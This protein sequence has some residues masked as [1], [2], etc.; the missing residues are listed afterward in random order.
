MKLHDIMK[1]FDIVNF[2]PDSLYRVSI[3]FGKSSQSLV[4]RSL[5]TILRMNENDF[6]LES[7]FNGW[8]TWREKLLW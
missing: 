8:I 3:V 1:K 2:F 5:K 4:K 7:I 6:S